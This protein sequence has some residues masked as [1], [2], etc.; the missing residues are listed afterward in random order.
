MPAVPTVKCPRCRAASEYHA[1]IEMLDPPVG[2][3][4]I[5]YC[6]AC[7]CLFEQVRDTGTA[8]ESTS[9]PPVCR[10]CR[11]PVSATEMGGTDPD[12]VVRYQCR[13]HVERWEHHV[14]A[15]RWTRLG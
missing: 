14:R 1:T 12:R 8:Y 13:E 2:K 5:G 4:D 15:D 3:I 7:S 11:Q 6:A 9:W 10:K